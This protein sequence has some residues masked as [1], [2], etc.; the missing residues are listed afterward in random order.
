LLVLDS[1]VSFL[2]PISICTL[3]SRSSSLNE[4]ASSKPF[5]I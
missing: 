2:S 4:D 5:I 1:I 3:V